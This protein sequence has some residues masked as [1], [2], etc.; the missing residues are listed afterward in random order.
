MELSTRAICLEWLAS[1]CSH[2]YAFGEGPSELERQQTALAELALLLFLTR[3]A[4]R[5][6]LTAAESACLA[7]LDLS[8]R[9]AVLHP[10]TQSFIESCPPAAIQA[11]MLYRLAAPELFAQLDERYFCSPSILAG[12]RDRPRIRWLEFI[13]LGDMLGLR[14]ADC[15]IGDRYERDSNPDD[16]PE[17]PYALTHMVFYLT[18]FGRQSDLG[19][20]DKLTDA[21]LRWLAAAVSIGDWDVT[22]EC[23]MCLNYLGVD[24]SRSR[25]SALS[26]MRQHA[27]A[28]SATG[29]MSRNTQEFFAEYHKRLVTVL[30]LWQ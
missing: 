4:P 30:A 28:G 18:R 21:C 8:F 14:L 5:V 10:S 20:V 17:T 12:V 1:N 7:A 25:V 22:A 16:I 19:D 11:P 29:S 23:V 3:T 24:A 6:G 26:S 15:D 2:F 13:A 27:V 9:R